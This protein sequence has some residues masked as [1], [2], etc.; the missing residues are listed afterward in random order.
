MCP[1]CSVSLTRHNYYSGGRL[2]CHYCGYTVPVPD[3]CPNCGGEHIQY[4]GFGTQKVEEEISETFSPHTVMRMD[5]DTTSSKFSYDE[6]LGKFRRHEAD[7]LLGTQMVT[8]GHDFPDVTLSGVLLADMS[9]YLDDYRAGERTFSLITQVIGRAGRQKK[10]GKAI[11]QTFNPE[12]PVLK[13][14]A[15]QDYKTFYKNEI[16]LRRSLVFPPFCDIFLITVTSKSEDEC[17]S[18][19]RNFYNR[20]I[21]GQKN[22]P[23]VKLII[24]G[25][26]EA[27]VYK[28]NE[29]YRWRFIIKA[30]NNKATRALFADNIRELC[31]KSSG[32]YTIS[33]DINPNNI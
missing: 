4:M 1:H 17:I 27:P 33:A 30:K 6:M 8:K 31:S 20:L 15:A 2:V 7:I 12:H 25:P 19:C 26:F 18:A 14:A 32:R 28:V 10:P 23:S 16:A 13:L 9:L 24:F 3:R 5:A 21:A 29:K 11:I 22:L